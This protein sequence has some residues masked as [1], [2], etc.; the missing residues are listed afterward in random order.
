MRCLYWRAGR[1]ACDGLCLLFFSVCE[2]C[3][4]DAC[5]LPPVSSWCFYLFRQQIEDTVSLLIL[6]FS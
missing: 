4:S 1:W 3:F 2:S 6:I 5:L